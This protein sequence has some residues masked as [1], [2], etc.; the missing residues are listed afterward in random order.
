MV[1]FKY[2]K[3]SPEEPVRRI[4]PV[5]VRYVW[6]VTA[7]VSETWEGEA[8]AWSVGKGDRACVL[9]RHRRGGEGWVWA[10]DVT[11]LDV[12]GPTSGG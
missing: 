5:R 6:R 12:A 2:P 3:P 8:V 4:A 7:T 10:E 9:I 11:R 1:K